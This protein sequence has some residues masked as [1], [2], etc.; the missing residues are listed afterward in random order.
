MKS[1][2]PGLHQKSL[3]RLVGFI[4]QF[5]SLNFAGDQ[6]LKTR[7]STYIQIHDFVNVGFMDTIG[8]GYGYDKLQKLA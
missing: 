4:H 7:L 3:N 6:E 5:K 1:G 2:K 8:Y